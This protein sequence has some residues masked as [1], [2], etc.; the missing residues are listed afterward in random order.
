MSNNPGAMQN[1]LL[2]FLRIIQK[3]KIFSTVQIHDNQCVWSFFYI[4]SSDDELNDI[5]LYMFPLVFMLFAMRLVFSIVMSIQLI[6]SSTVEFSS[7]F[8]HSLVFS[9]VHLLTH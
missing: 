8:I 7:S 5:F 9:F 6:R 2:T 3:V 1:K 4:R